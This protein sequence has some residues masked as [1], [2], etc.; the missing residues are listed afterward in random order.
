MRARPFLL[1]TTVLSCSAW[2]QTYTIS[3]FAGG[4]LPVNIPG[5][6]ASLASGS[7]QCIAADPAGN[8]FFTDQNSVLRLDATTGL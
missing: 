8:L 1:L 3:T 4:G 5:T 6:S 2:G 7:P